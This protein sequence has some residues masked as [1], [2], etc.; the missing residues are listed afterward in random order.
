MGES[1]RGLSRPIQGFSLA[2]AGLYVTAALVAV[3]HSHAAIVAGLA[4]VFMAAGLVPPIPNPSGG[5]TFPVNNVKIVA[6]LIWLPQDVLLGV[7]IGSCV[8]LLLF[9][10]SELWRAGNNGAGW[11]LATAAAAFAGHAAAARIEPGLLQFFVA[12][13][14][15]VSVNRIVNEGIFAV[16]KHLRFGH[17]LSA[18]WRQNVIDQWDIQL[19]AAPMAILLASIAAR[20]GN[21]WAALG[22]TAVSAIAL[23]I[24]RQ[25]LASYHRSQQAVG[26]I[27]EA[28]V[29]VLE[30]VDPR[31]REHGERV[32][33]LATE[34]GR[35]L[36]MSEATIRSMR[37]AARL[38]DVGMLAGPS[39][40]SET[41]AHHASAGS[42][43]LA[44]FPDPLVARIVRAHHERWDGRGVPDG[45]RG[46]RI[47]LAARILA[48]AEAYEDAQHQAGAGAPRHALKRLRAMRGRDLDPQVVDALVAA[49][50]EHRKNAV[51]T[52]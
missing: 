15:I 9:S 25:E 16:Y 46:R 47:P 11:G 40:G 32:G 43:I 48:A 26:E 51:A 10:R 42:A 27:V 30:G 39:T 23:P 29:R 24:P 4:L 20:L 52:R 31:A 1:F 49:L 44:R 36:R 37:L 17:P 50:A 18:T 12:A 2:L 38:H 45:K 41:P 6:A 34:V 22:L 7:G 21:A 35:R 28:V 5:S 3:P 13:V 14:V 33:S 8:G 19:L